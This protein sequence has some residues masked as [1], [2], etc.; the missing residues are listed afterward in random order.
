MKIL[1]LACDLFQ[2]TGGGQVVYQKVIESTPTVNF[3]YFIDQE[4]ENNSRPMN[5]NV[6]RLPSPRSVRFFEPILL[7]D[8]TRGTIANIDRLAYAVKDLEFD[9]IEYPDFMLYGKYLKA[10][11]KKYNIFYKRLSIALHGSLSITDSL[12]WQHNFFPIDYYEREKEQYLIADGAYGISEKLFEYYHKFDSE[13]IYWLDPISFILSSSHNSDIKEDDKS[14]PSLYGVGR[15]ERIKGNDLL[16]Q[17]AKL[18]R[19][20]TYDEIVH[21]GQDEKMPNNMMASD[22]LQHLSECYDVPFRYISNVP[23][24]NIQELYRKKMVLF[25]LSRFDSFNL[26]ALEAI[27]SGCLCVISSNCYICHYLD[28]YYPNLP[29]IKARMD[30]DNLSIQNLYALAKEVQLFIDHYDDYK[31]NLMEQ[32][33]KCN[34]EPRS[35]LNLENYY[36]AILKQKHKEDIYNCSLHYDSR[37]SKSLYIKYR[38]ICE[39]IYHKFKNIMTSPIE[40]L[41]NCVYGYNKQYYHFIK[42]HNLY[43]LTKKTCKNWKKISHYSERSKNHIQ[44]KL[45]LL[46]DNEHIRLYRCNKW[47]EIARLKERLGDGVTSIAY[48]LRLLRLCKNLSHQSPLYVRKMLADNNLSYIAK[49]VAV[50]HGDD[51]EEQTLAFLQDRYQ[52]HKNYTKKTFSFIEDNRNGS[53]FK[54]SIIVSLYN[55]ES[56]MRFFLESLLF[57]PSPLIKNNQVEFIF[58]DSNSPTNEYSVYKEI[59]K[60]QHFSSIYTKSQERETIQSAWNRGISL[61]T[62]PYLVFLGVDETLLPNALSILTDILDHNPDCDWVMGNSWVTKVEETGVFK[63][64]IMSYIRDN[65]T[66]EHQYLDTCY[67]SYVGGM[68]RRSI[69]EKHG[70]YDENFTGAGDTEFKNRVFPFIKIKYVPKMLGVFLNYPEERT[71]QSAIVEVEDTLAWYINRTPGGI[72]YAFDNQDIKVVEELLVLSLSYRKSYCN[73]ISTDIEYAYYLCL[74]LLK[75]DPSSYL[76]SALK[77]DLFD[78]LNGFYY[79]E[80]AQKKPSAL[81]VTYRGFIFDQKIKNMEEKHSKIIN[82]K[83]YYNISNDNRYEQ[84]SWLWK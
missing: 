9:I 49:A 19:K 15:L 13:N 43:H 5:A 2:K 53:S 14:L 46:Y 33:K 54:V 27:F 34:T 21:V 83:L 84:H 26:V 38:R 68:Y 41:A 77:D 35:T 48:Q 65:A 82:K 80:Y 59:L 76:A 78:F 40:F 47:Q 10:V 36:K 61:S 22:F 37:D 18:I 74:Y 58:I 4:H 30:P 69:H 52:H 55:A 28:K 67:L 75:R 64:E 63:H 24:S 42:Y 3:T 39:R 72:R 44:Q 25:V 79:L 23:R 1:I 11:L 56:K 31:E 16:I 60:E 7:D 12:N 29:Y 6:V 8:S 81:Y 17:L 57:N 66:K 51:S 71:T 45:E 20:D 73:H 70:Y 32:L 50:M 62:A